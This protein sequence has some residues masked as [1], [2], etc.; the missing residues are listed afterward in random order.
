MKDQ[1]AN[2]GHTQTSSR[3]LS[4]GAEV[5]NGSR[6]RCCR[7]G[8]GRGRRSNGNGIPGFLPFSR[9]RDQDRTR[10]EVEKKASKQANAGGKRRGSASVGY[11]RRKRQWLKVVWE[12]GG[13][14]E[15]RIVRSRSD[16]GPGSASG[17]GR[18]SKVHAL[19]LGPGPSPS[20]QSKC[21]KVRGIPQALQTLGTGVNEPLCRLV[22]GPRPYL[23][24]LLTLLTALQMGCI[25]GVESGWSAGD[26][27]C[28]MPAS[29]RPSTQSLR[30]LLQLLR[31]PD[32][33]APVRDPGDLSWRL[34]AESAPQ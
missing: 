12:D 15:A 13:R 4:D 21:S 8:R 9:R 1:Q 10:I 20:P 34:P 33:T 19:A 29:E 30:S 11:R 25:R 31:A 6:S 22:S 26:D 3:G 18:S 2:G 7:G 14:A 17:P 16:G 23:T 5:E 28:G 24:C 32:W 27:S